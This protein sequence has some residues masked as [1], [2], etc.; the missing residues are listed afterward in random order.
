MSEALR[1]REARGLIQRSTSSKDRRASI[2]T[3]TLAGKRRLAGAL[4]AV[5]TADRKFFGAPA[6]G[7]LLGDLVLLARTPGP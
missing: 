7:S 3:L 1:R 4:P 2:V 6:G 5:E